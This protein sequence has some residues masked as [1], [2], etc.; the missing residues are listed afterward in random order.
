[1]LQ[2]W[3][4]GFWQVGFEAGKA[5]AW[6]RL[7]LKASGFRL[8][9]V[10]S[11]ASAGFRLVLLKQVK[12]F[13]LLFTGLCRLMALC[14]F[15][16]GFCLLRIKAYAGLGFVYFWF[17]WQDFRF[18]LKQASGLWFWKSLRLIF[19]CLLIKALNAVFISYRVLALYLWKAG[20][21]IFFVYSFFLNLVLV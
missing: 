4:Y 1:M 9:F 17:A 15:C 19:F 2:L 16:Y 21:V 20:G 5:L 8:L 18:A 7:R 3:G 11:L 14:Y 13:V 12:G 10:V 6:W